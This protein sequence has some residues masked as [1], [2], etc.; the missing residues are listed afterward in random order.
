MWS[1]Y[2]IHPCLLYPVLQMV[3]R[4]RLY[5]P[6]AKAHE[7]QKFL[8]SLRAQKAFYYTPP[9]SNDDWCVHVL[10]LLVRVLD[11]GSDCDAG[12]YG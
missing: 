5:D 11:G 6:E 10:M 8:D 7:V 2:M 4:K 1:P 3:H 9:G 12:I